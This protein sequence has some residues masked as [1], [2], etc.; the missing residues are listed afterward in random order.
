MI[1]IDWPERS[2]PA[3]WR[4]DGG[5]VVVC[6]T[7]DV[8]AESPILA[9]GDHYAEHLST[10]S[11]QAFGPRKGLDRLL[12]VLQGCDVPA[13]VFIPGETAVRWPSTVES[14]AEG[15][16]E[17]A[18]HGFSHRH[19]VHL[20]ADEQRREVDAAIETLTRFG[21]DPVGYRAPNWEMHSVTLEH[22]AA[23][24]LQYD[25]SLMDD[26]EPYVLSLAEGRLAELPP[27][28]SLDDWEQYFF[29]PEPD[30]GQRIV[31]PSQV[32]QLW[33]EELEAM[34]RWGGLLV[35]TLH[36]F[37]SGRAS[38]ARAL[39]Q[40]IE[41]AQGYDDVEF[42]TCSEIAGRV[43]GDQGGSIVPKY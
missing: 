8:D 31:P 27:H 12:G 25:S 4:R 2:E 28:W 38:R 26:D 33:S 35:L 15:G 3:P 36:P 19:P 40:F 20:S 37:L 13:T 24:G 43:L 32:L 18:L 23:R 9:R 41:L 34:R 1:E 22:L 42:A 16:Y 14:A 21:V 30:I 29:V 39:E 11:H 6:V 5:K 17:V 10:L 7:I